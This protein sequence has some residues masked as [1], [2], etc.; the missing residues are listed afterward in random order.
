MTS[1]CNLNRNSKSNNIFNL[2]YNS[3]NNNNNN[4]IILKIRTF[5]NKK[6]TKTLHNCRIKTNNIIICNKTFQIPN[7]QE[8]PHKFLN[9]ISYSLQTRTKCLKPITI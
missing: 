1:R 7:N 4:S 2:N 3:N 8:M 9:I 6:R 5:L